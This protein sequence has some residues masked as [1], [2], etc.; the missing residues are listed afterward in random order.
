[1]AIQPMDSVV[2]V[3]ALVGCTPSAAVCNGEGI[4]QI[5]FIAEGE[6]VLTLVEPIDL[7][8]PDA[9]FTI[10]ASPSIP[11]NVIEIA[12]IDETHVR[13]RFRNPEDGELRAGGCSF[14]LC[15]RHLPVVPAV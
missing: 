11:A 3:L 6:V 7:T 12:A 13:V 14:M 9:G 15:R 4:S 1:M 8:P 5:Q 2:Q 10:F